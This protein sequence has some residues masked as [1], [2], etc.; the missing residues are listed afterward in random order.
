MKLQ[1]F[2]NISKIYYIYING[3]F[4]KLCPNTT[5]DQQNTSGSHG[6]NSSSP[7]FH[8]AITTCSHQNIL[9]VCIRCG[10]CEDDELWFA[11]DESHIIL[12]GQI[13]QVRTLNLNFSEHFLC[14]FPLGKPPF[15]MSCMMIIIIIDIN[16]I[17]D[18]HYYY[19]DEDEDNDDDTHDDDDDTHSWAWS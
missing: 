4:H 1:A 8:Q 10:R 18:Y 13:V 12:A 11:S 3:W 17:I 14:E 7:E 16:I 15:V 9:A 2:M 5:D 6:R 19:D